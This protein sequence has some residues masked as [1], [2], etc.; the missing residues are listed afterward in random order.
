MAN[1]A[2]QVLIDDQGFE[3]SETFT[4]DRNG[5][6][7]HLGKVVSKFALVVKSTGTAATA[8]SVTLKGSLDGVT[9]DTLITQATGDGDGI[10]KYA[11]DKP[12]RWVRLDMSGIT[13][14][15][16]TNVIAKAIAMQ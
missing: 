5:T 8:W 14:S 4:A 7:F 3:F 12:V 15:P 11:V 2:E 9:W 16:A 1:Q 6:G 13:L 10:I